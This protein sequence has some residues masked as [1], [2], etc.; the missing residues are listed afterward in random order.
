MRIRLSA[1]AERVSCLE[2]D[3]TSVSLPQDRYDLWHDRAVFHFRTDPE[4]RKKYLVNLTRALKAG[5]YIV[6]GTF[7]LEAP[8]RCGGLPVQR[9]SPEALQKEFGK[10]FMPERHQQECT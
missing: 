10:E 5:G 9:Y 6:I 7:A 2:G 3:I 8:P 1:R 4:Q